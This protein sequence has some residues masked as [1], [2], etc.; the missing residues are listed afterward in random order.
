[1]HERAVVFGEVATLLE[2][3]CGRRP[4]TIV[5]ELGPG[6]TQPVVESAW[7]E[8]VRGTTLERAPVRWRRASDTLR[9]LDCADEYPGEPLTRCPHCGG[10][11]LV[12]EPAPEF[13]ATS[14]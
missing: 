13:R 14:G 8:A 12:V 5:V 10:D 9:C 3:A 11:G 7:D 4:H 2:A 6:M 1:M